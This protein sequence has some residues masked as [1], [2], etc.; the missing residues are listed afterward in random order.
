MVLG[1]PDLV[2]GRRSQ[3]RFFRSFAFYLSD[4]I[5][6]HSEEKEVA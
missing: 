2:G 1:R 4:L 5:L 6:K 3:I